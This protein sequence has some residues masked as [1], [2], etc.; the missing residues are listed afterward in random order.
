[1]RCN[2]AMI[3]IGKRVPKGFVELAGSIH[4]G[5]GMW[6]FNIEKEVLKQ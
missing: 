2:E 1:M 3:Y 5:R 6:M 4:L